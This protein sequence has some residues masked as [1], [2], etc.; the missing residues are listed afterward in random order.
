MKNN[1]KYRGVNSY[2]LSGGKINSYKFIKAYILFVLMIVT[3]F[4][5][6]RFK[7]S[8]KITNTRYINESSNVY[9]EE[10]SIANATTNMSNEKNIEVNLNVSLDSDKMEFLQKVA[11]GAIENYYKYGILPSITIAQAILESGWGQ[12]DLAVTH[13]NLFGIK[14]D[15]RWD[16]DIATI[17]TSENYNDIT[18]ASFRKYNNIEESINDH[19]KF[20]YENSRYSEYGLFAGKNYI[21]QAQA[22]EDAGY[23]T[24]RNSDG[25]P[26]YA[27][28]LVTL[29]EKYNL[30]EYDNKVKN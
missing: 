13:N 25:V 29:I 14:A 28:K 20:L 2:A 23:S 11:E 16:G 10:V 1:I 22:L 9:N 6:I 27:D 3:I 26:V 18:I 24:V 17:S 8:Q 12:S 5:T 15:S 19:G 4:S 7:L 21:Q 30:M